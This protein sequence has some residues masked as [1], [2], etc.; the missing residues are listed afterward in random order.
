[1][2]LSPF[3]ESIKKARQMRIIQ[4][5][6]KLIYYKL[7]AIPAMIYSAHGMAIAFPIALYRA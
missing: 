6:Q 1:M 3:Y 5:A 2:Q 7:S 4:H